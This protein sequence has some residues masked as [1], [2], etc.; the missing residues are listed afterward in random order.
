VIGILKGSPDKQSIILNGHV[1]VVSPEPVADW[2]HDPWG[3]DIVGNRLYGRGACDMK[4]GVIANLYALKALQKMG[5]DPVGTVM[6]QSVIEEEDGG[7]GTLACLA[8]GFTADGMIVP[9]PSPYV[10]VA[11]A[12]IKRFRVRIPGR[13]AHPAE[14]Q[15]GVN[16]IGKAM[17]L[18]QALERL[19]AHRKSTV[20][21]PLLEQTGNP[22]AHLVIGTMSGGDHISTVAGFAEMG[23]RIGFVPG[24]TGDDI[25]NLVEDT[26]RGA[27]GRDDW[28]RE[29]PPVIQWLP[30]QCESYYQ[31]PEH[32]FVQTVVAAVKT[33]AKD[34]G[35][36]QIK[37]NTW[38]EDTRLAQYFD[39]PALSHG[40]RGL[41]PHGVDE[42][43][44]L[45][46]VVQ[47]TKIL[48]YSV[49]EWCNKT[50]P[51]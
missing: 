35:A 4:A 24:E 31:D 15:K 11:L 23:C 21:Y 28:L 5:H 22:A 27:A 19:D 29:H 16:A 8:E 30:F 46:S 10:N 41:R 42:C 12:G 13:P 25:R 33:F 40:P 48:A 2:Q 9:E 47:L 17:L 45:D 44:D 32:P 36:A 39:F 20:R 3:G 26:I 1:D 34:P 37:G 49:M 7:A 18:Y 43:V 51:A 6:L 14:S 38:S 50:R